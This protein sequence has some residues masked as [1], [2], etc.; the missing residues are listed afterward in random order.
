MLS[1]T[2]EK[3]T[4]VCWNRSLSLPR[5]VHDIN[6]P[7]GEERP[8]YQPVTSFKRPMAVVSPL[9]A[10]SAKQTMIGVRLSST[11]DAV[12]STDNHLVSHGLSAPP[13]IV[14]DVVDPPEFG[15]VGLALASTL[16]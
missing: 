13:V 3:S 9:A 15:L 11:A 2:E 10:S 5:C 7:S 8:R 16:D 12:S 1:L 4:L 14:H 6:Y